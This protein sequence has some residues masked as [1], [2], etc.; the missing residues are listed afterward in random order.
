[1]LPVQ[2]SSSSVEK[3][4]SNQNLPEPSVGIPTPGTVANDSATT[5]VKA[6]RPAG[7]P[8]LGLIAGIACYVM[9]GTLPVYFVALAPA[10]PVEII[11]HR[12]VWS[13]IFCLALL[14]IMRKWGSFVTALKDRS[15]LKTL[16][17]AS[18]LIVINWLTYVYAVS[19]Q[20]TIDAALGYYINPLVTVL[21]AVV[22]LREKVAPLTWIGL[23]VGVVAVIVMTAG[24]GRL[25]WI[26][27]VL[28]F[29]FGFYGFIKSKVGSKVDSITS[30]SVETLLV[31][32]VAMTYLLW[33]QNNGTSTFTT[34]GTM[35][36][37]LL[38]AAGVVTAVPLIFFG[39]A[40]QKLPLTTL[41]ILQYLGPTLQF[42]FALVVFHE[43]MP[44]ARWIG[45]F[46][47]W[48]AIVLATI[49]TARQ[50]KSARKLQQ[51]A[52]STTQLAQPKESPTP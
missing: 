4:S 50:S 19:T 28:A 20:A 17:L 40:A 26:S 34:E 2:L 45:F 11:A 43:P 7:A 18:V 52:Q 9:W 23:G 44:T 33:L 21:F 36:S 24:M 47:V 5:S 48:I 14:V 22:F 39:Y 32:P 38:M 46:L 29:S 41:G 12:I 15:I 31:A 1:M 25:P 6:P 35:H 37:V 10:G 16:G 51:A 30:L 8:R 13:L 42:I 3:V 27:L 49:G